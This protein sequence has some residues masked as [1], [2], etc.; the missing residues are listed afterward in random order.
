MI[1]GDLEIFQKRFG[2]EGSVIFGVESRERKDRLGNYD[3]T[4]ELNEIFQNIK[5]SFIAFYE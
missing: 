5:K 1:C 3:K 4:S 2:G